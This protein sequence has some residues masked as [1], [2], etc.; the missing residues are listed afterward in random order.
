MTPLTIQSRLLYTDRISAQCD[1]VNLLSIGDGRDVFCHLCLQRETEPT[2]VFSQ[3]ASLTHS[4]KKAA[5]TKRLF[6]DFDRF[7][8]DCA[9]CDEITDGILIR[10]FHCAQKLTFSLAC[11]PRTQILPL[12]PYRDQCGILLRNESKKLLMIT[13]RK[14]VTYTQGALSL[15]G[16]GMLFFA[17]T[18]E[19]DSAKVLARMASMRTVKEDERAPSPTP[20]QILATR[21]CKDGRILPHQND[22]RYDPDTQ[23]QVLRTLCRLGKECDTVAQCL[24]THLQGA[25]YDAGS[26][27]GVLA[28]LRYALKSNMPIPTWCEAILKESARHLLCSMMPFAVRDALPFPICEHGSLRRTLEWLSAVNLLLC[29]QESALREKAELVQKRLSENFYSNG[30]WSPNAPHRAQAL[31]HPQFRMGICPTCH[32]RY[33]EKEVVTLTYHKGHKTY[34]CAKCAQADDLCLDTKIPSLFEPFGY[35]E[36]AQPDLDLAHCNIEDL[37]RFAYLFRTPTALESLRARLQSVLLESLSSCAL[38]YLLEL[39]A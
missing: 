19:C 33:G 5:F 6:S 16:S 1:G 15:S 24:S 36:Y 4:K 14:G 32:A 12:S 21:V 35:C 3:N 28:F 11:A 37:I 20:A 25:P 7:L 10:T 13:W 31:R 30:S 17:V 27:I 26:A 22:D 18:T 8:A 2:V 34:L 9:F 23:A 39:E 29:N 38:C